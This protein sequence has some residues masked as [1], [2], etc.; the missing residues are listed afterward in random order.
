MC[1]IFPFLSKR[2]ISG[3]VYLTAAQYVK[4]ANFDDTDES[5]MYFLK[6]YQQRRVVIQVQQHKKPYIFFSYIP[7]SSIFRRKCIVKEEKLVETKK[8]R[9]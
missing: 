2:F 5:C 9:N 3:V 1:P 6:A 8:R 4:T 7:S